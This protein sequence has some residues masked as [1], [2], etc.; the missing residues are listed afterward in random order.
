ML[1][2]SNVVDGGEFDEK[3]RSIHHNPVKA[4]LVVR[5]ED[6]VWGSARW[7]AGIRE[8]GDVACVSRRV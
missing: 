8:V 2:R 6:W 4:G 5:A 3:V 7:W 1:F